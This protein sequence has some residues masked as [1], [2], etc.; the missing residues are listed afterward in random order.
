MKDVRAVVL[1]LLVVVLVA[2][3]LAWWKRPVAELPH[4]KGFQ[5]EIQDKDGDSVRRVS[6]RIPARLVAGIARRAPIEEALGNIQAEWGHGDITPRDIL[7]AA[8][9]STPGQPGVIKKDGSTVEVVTDGG[10]LEIDIRDDWGKKVHLRFPRSLLEVLADNSH[11]S[12]AEVL[13]RIDELGPGD[14]VKV[15][16][17]D[18]EVTITAQGR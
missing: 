14:V 15:V 5:V 2:L 16:S 11:L 13:R 6:F 1:G 17:D 12:T 8:S 7:D 4:L 3:G 10:A 9:R 18:A